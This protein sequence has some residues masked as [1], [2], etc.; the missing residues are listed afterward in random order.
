[1][2]DAMT[3]TNHGAAIP[4]PQVQSCDRV[5]TVDQC[6]WCGGTGVQVEVTEI[7]D[8]PDLHYRWRCCG[9]SY[10]VDGPDA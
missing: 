2:G 5:V 3:H 1:M 6:R 9:K 10:C 7:N 4:L 8:Y